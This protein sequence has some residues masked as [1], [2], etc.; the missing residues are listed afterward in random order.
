MGPENKLDHKRSIMPILEKG[1]AILTPVNPLHYLPMEWR[2]NLYVVAS[3]ALFPND[4]IDTNGIFEKAEKLQEEGYGLV[5]VTRHIS[6]RDFLMLTGLFRKMSGMTRDGSNEREVYVPLAYHQQGLGVKGLFEYFEVFPKTVVT[7]ETV[8][9]GKNI[10]PSGRI[11]QVGHGFRQYLGAASK[12]LDTGGVVFLAPSGTRTALHEL[13]GGR[14]I[15]SLIKLTKTDK[16]AFV[17]VGLDIPNVESYANCRGYRFFRKY[18]VTMG[19]IRTKEELLQIASAK[20]A[21]DR[22]MAND[23]ALVVRPE[24]LGE[25]F[26]ELREQLLTQAA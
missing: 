5:L 3:Q 12:A 2:R 9:K 1:A 21:A 13:W 22:L 18:V 17:T 15:E 11:L 8:K 25:S 10:D 7:E 4:C 23:M 26:R 20:G 19:S 24:T 16:V 6:A 14:P